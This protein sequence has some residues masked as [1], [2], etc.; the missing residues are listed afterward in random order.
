MVV[1]EVRFELCFV[2]TSSPGHVY[3]DIYIWFWH[4]KWR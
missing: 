4:E 1:V 2:I 3:C